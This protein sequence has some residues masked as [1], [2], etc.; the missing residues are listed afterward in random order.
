MVAH[1]T[2]ADGVRVRVTAGQQKQAILV[3]K[4]V[5]FEFDDNGK[6]VKC[7]NDYF[8]DSCIKFDF[9]GGGLKLSG[10]QQE[11][12]DKMGRD[13][14][15]KNEILLEE[16][17]REKQEIEF[18]RKQID[19]RAE[20][21]RMAAQNDAERIRHNALSDA[22]KIRMAAYNNAAKWNKAID[23]KIDAMI[24]DASKTFFGRILEKPIW[25]R[26]KRR[27]VSKRITKSDIV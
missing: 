20:K 26:M 6:I 4:S 7:S 25:E 16:L 3:M 23:A 5:Y 9:V 15:R 8:G 1:I 11:R 18:E 14:A 13:L 2:L 12:F 22:G 10:G 27:W 24:K 19:S 21:I 17:R